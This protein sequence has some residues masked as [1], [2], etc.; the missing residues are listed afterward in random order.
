M[1]IQPLVSPDLARALGAAVEKLKVASDE[2]A[3]PVFASD[4][5]LLHNVLTE[6]RVRQFTFQVDEPP[7][8]GG[9]DQAPNPVELVLAALGTCQEIVYAAYAAV[10]GIELDAVEITVRGPLDLRGLFGL[11]S[12]PSGFQHVEMETRIRS[13]EAPEAIRRLVSTVQA[14][15]PVLDII[16]RPLEVR[17]EVALNEEPLA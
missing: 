2:Q 5:R 12:A 1:S 13:R 15:C 6:A 10:L 16:Q 17:N 14:H 4:T 11:S 9:T 7:L 3:T 8:L